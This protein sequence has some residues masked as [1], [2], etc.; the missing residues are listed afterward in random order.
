MNTTYYFWM[1]KVVKT[2]PSGNNFLNRCS[3]VLLSAKEPKLLRREWFQIGR[4][5]R[6]NDKANANSG[7]RFFIG[8]LPSNS[9]FFTIVIYDN[10]YQPVETFFMPGKCGI[11]ARKAGVREGGL[12][13][14]KL[15][16]KW[17]V[18]PAF[19]ITL[20]VLLLPSVWYLKTEILMKTEK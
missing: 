17:D 5:V 11:R 16:G 20:Y 12:E 2:I 19:F 1:S 7:K 6:Q 4:I 13:V 14:E 18:N 8:V 10:K 9:A 15:V 3:Y